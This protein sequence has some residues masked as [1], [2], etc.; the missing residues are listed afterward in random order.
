MRFFGDPFP[1]KL[2]TFDWDKEKRIEN[3]GENNEYQ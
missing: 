3:T 1:I 2:G